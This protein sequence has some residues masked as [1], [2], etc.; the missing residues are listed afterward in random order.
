MYI[1]LSLFWTPATFF[2]PFLDT[3][4]FELKK[5]DCVSIYLNLNRI[6]LNSKKKNVLCMICPLRM[7]H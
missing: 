2:I 1:L 3:F 6:E 7:I 4:V 5:I